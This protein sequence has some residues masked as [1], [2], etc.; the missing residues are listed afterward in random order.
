MSIWRT[1]FGYHDDLA[2][3]SQTS[4]V[5]RFSSVIGGCR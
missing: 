2:W 5:W 4:R 1:R 3:H